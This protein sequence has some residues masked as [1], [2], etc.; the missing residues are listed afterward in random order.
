M[1]KQLR[2]L[3]TLLLMAVAS[4][5]WGDEVV[6]YTLDT[7]GSLQGTNN[8]Y[9]G[10]CDILSDGITWNLTGNSKI[11][12]WRIGGKSITNVD[13]TV[14]TK[15]AMG[16]AISKLVLTL[17]TGANVT[18]NS[19]KLTVASDVDFLNVIDEVSITPTLSAD[20]T[21]SPS[22]GA[23]WAANSYYKFTFNL[24]ISET[25]NK[26]VQFSKVTFYKEKAA[27]AKQEAEVTI[28]STTLDLNETTEVT[29]DGPALTLTT[30][31][32][33]V[34]SVSGTTVTG[35][36]VGTATITATWEEDD[37]FEAGS[38]N[39]TV[40][41]TD[42]N[43]PG[44]VNNPYS[45]AQARA[46]IDANEGITGVYAKGIVS[47]IV[48]AFSSEYGNISYNISTDGTTS[49]DQL[50]AYRGKSYNGESFTS[51]DDIQVGD[52]VVV[53]GNLKKHNSTYEFDAGNQLVS[54]KR[55]TKEEAGLAFET[56]E[57]TIN[58]GETF[59]A[60]TLTNPNNLEVT[61]ESSNTNV[62]TVA[63]DGTV[64]L[65]TVAG[66][67]EIT[68][69]F[70]GN[71]NYLPGSASY[72][73]TVVDQNAH[74]TADQPYT[75]AEAIEFINTLGTT[76]SDVVYVKGVIS[77]VD[78]YNGTYKSITYWISDDGTTATQ[79]Q[80][81]SG[82]GLDSA[83]FSSKDDLKVGDE[84][85]VRGNVKL[86]N[87]TPEFDKN[88]YLVAFNRP[89]TPVVLPVP[90]FSPAAGA[91][92]AGTTVT[93]NI[94]E[95]E[96]VDY[97]EYSFDQTTWKEYTD[98]TVITINEETT[99]YAR[100]VGTKPDTYSEVA[101]ATYTIKAVTVAVLP[102]EWAGGA[103]A[104]FLALDG[105]T[106]EGLGTS[107]Y[108]ETHNPYNIKLDTTGDYIQVNT[109]SQ[110]GKVIVGVKMVGGAT[111]STITVQESA[112]GVNFTNVQ[113]LSI[114]GKQNDVLSLETTNAFAA[115]SRYVRLTFTKG[116][117]VG[118]G[119]I[120]ITKPATEIVAEETLEIDAR[121]I[122]G[123]IAY[124]IAYPETGVALTAAADVDWISDVT[125]ASD[126]VTFTTTVNTGA[127]RSGNITLTYGTLTKV[128]KVT[129]AAAP[130]MYTLTIGNPENV[131]IT[132][133]YNVDQVINNGESAELENG[134]EVTFALTIPEG[135]ALESLTVAG[136]EEGQT[137]TPT[138]N[139]TTPGVY[140]FTMPAFNV[141]I[142]ATVAKIE[143][144]TYTL[145]TSVT[146]GKRYIIVGFNENTYK[147]M[148]EQ[149]SNN[150]AAVEISVNDKTATV[151]STAGAYE[152]VIDGNAED[153][154]TIY[155]ES[156]ESTGYLYAASS[157]K[158]WLKTQKE[159]DVNGLWT[160]TFGEGG[161]AS[162][163]ASQSQNRNV[164]QYN[165]SSSLFACYAS[166]SQSPVY[167]YEKEVSGETKVGDVNKDGSVTIADVTAL[168]N[169]LL[170]KDKT[171]YDLNAANVDGANG[172]TVADVEALVNLVLK[173]TNE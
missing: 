77:K 83:D 62:A 55:S 80:V 39:F 165:S 141:T 142:N 145:A 132:A 137:V 48:T 82:K 58:L 120:T 98:E 7:T 127:E 13:R 138:E 3:C 90:T 85:T 149:R 147:A 50:Q 79:M 157:E 45:V 170:N 113:A 108:G 156:E 125:V 38:K 148:G 99:I 153:G 87:G 155:D 97:V 119:P 65:G 24:T 172:I 111:A 161:V 124:S 11:N 88:N 129:Q 73:L 75:V 168:V 17:G 71:D 61:W 171:A 41:V 1:I 110:P 54:L 152:F 116:S 160:I 31:D 8:S 173:Q 74:G 32:E 86:Y 30:S 6:Y 2:Y 37:N 104:N 167:L 134:T 49:S 5:A 4:V 76:T 154:Y 164:M 25:S 166:A 26:F 112:D 93:I 123:E 102:F 94:P 47:E 115:E 146:P 163:Q 135:Y 118:V 16:S 9:T 162:L 57:F 131:T 121:A 34:A 29:T 117:N 140:T 70:A 68:A 72:R 84:V 67:T 105:V 23:E 27:D 133:T 106:A 107:D 21:F 130:Q 12:P 35:V 144:T 151:P 40:T 95:D 78:S 139:A 89:A 128:V 56:T 43:G 36:A 60:P 28:G 100:S 159:N 14:Y 169:I 51:E 92:E 136:A 66:Y 96:N 81:Y 69:S 33:T 59:T 91:V 52:E 46:A 15:T 20:N 44:T 122:S 10:N 103:S 64:T 150:R 101:S 143:T 18:I 63:N 158:N 53:F 114:S 22:G 109:D 19:L 126:K 42:P